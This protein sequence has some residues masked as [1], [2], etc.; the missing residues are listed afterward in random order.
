[1][2]F[3]ALL[4][5]EF[6]REQREFFLETQVRRVGCA[7]AVIRSVAIIAIETF[8]PVATV[9]V[10]AFAAA[11]VSLAVIASFASIG[12]IELATVDIFAGSGARDLSS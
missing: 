3:R 2:V 11:V 7:V 1:M 9:E 6:T 12:L 10:S 8:V 5:I 4:F